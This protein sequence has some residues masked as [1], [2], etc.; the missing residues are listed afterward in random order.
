MIVKLKPSIVYNVYFI[1]KKKSLFYELMLNYFV[2]R[3]TIKK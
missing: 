2:P 1:K 3:N